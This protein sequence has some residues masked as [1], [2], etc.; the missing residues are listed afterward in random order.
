MK[1]VLDEEQTMLANSVQ[2]LVSRNAPLS[3]VRALRDEHD[4]VGFSRELWRQCAELGFTGIPFPEALGG[5]G[6]RHSDLAVV[7]EALG[8]VLAPEPFL[9]TVLLAGQV[10][11]ECGDAAFAGPWIERIVSGE[12]ILA[13]AY[14]EAGSRYNTHHVETTA[15][16]DG[17]QWTL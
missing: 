16:Q 7:L 14:Q 6:M 2:G 3:R 1:L 5:H 4:P 13:L 10:L 12:A 15:T 9:S 17:E 11:A 8:G